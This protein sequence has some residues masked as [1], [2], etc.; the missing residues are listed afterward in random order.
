[1]S[2]NAL[3]VAYP[4]AYMTRLF[5]VNVTVASSSSKSMI[6]GLPMISG[7]VPS[8]LIPCDSW[9]IGQMLSS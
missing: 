3:L 2:K 6:E 9:M 5:L 7:T 4:W 8:L 1:M